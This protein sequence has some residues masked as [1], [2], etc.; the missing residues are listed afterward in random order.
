MGA[1]A[2]SHIDPGCLNLA[3]S[4][5]I[6]QMCQIFLHLIEGP[7]EQMAQIMRKYLPW[8]YLPCLAQLLHVMADI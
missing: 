5:D 6:S 7:C 2:Y 8:I 1:G 4:Q 3:V